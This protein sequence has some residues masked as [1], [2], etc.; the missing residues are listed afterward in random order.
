M[1]IYVN[2]DMDI[3][4]SKSLAEH[5]PKENAFICANGEDSDQPV[6]LQ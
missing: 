3:L 5:V 6:H 4:M 1:F 2:Q